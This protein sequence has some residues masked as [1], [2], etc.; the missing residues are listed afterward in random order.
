MKVKRFLTPRAIDRFKIMCGVYAF[1][2]SV[3]FLTSK[4]EGFSSYI[5][6]PA[7][8]PPYMFENE[9]Y[10]KMESRITPYG[11]VEEYTNKD[12]FCQR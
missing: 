5:E 12:I 9:S 7:E 1:V 2:M 8:S 4:A 11:Y 10:D 6:E 3:S